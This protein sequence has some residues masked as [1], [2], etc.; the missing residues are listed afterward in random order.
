MRRER[1]RERVCVCVCVYVCVCVI[2]FLIMNGWVS[3]YK[4]MRDRENLG[5]SCDKLDFFFGGH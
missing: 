2:I 3:V 5:F 1:E 4:Y